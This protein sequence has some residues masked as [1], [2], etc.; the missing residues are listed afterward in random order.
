MTQEAHEKISL[1]LGFPSQFLPTKSHQKRFKAQFIIKFL[2]LHH[3][4]QQEKI[5]SFFF[6]STIASIPFNLNLNLISPQTISNR[7]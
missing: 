2:W 4:I 1:S 3:K 5:F 7:L 6:S